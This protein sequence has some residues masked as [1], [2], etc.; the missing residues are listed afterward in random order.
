MKKGSHVVYCKDSERIEEILTL[1]GAQNAAL[2]LMGIKMYK[3]MRNNI[4]R[5]INFETANISRT[6]NAAAEQ[7]YAIETIL[8]G[9]NPCRKNSKKLPCSGWKT[10]K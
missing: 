6:A 2:E 7:V 1:M 9:W 3:D 4:N 8:E 5:K 10:R